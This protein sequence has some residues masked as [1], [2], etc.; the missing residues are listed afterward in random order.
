M[1][2][3][4]TVIQNKIDKDTYYLSIAKFRNLNDL[5]KCNKYRI[6]YPV[7]KMISI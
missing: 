6:T 1:S 4:Y 3:A 7:V 2:S 5:I